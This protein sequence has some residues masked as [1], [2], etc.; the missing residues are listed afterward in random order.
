MTQLRIDDQ[1]MDHRP[2]PTERRTV[3]R[4]V[5]A[6]VLQG[7]RNGNG[8]SV[9]D[10]ASKASMAPMTWRRLEEGLDVRRRAQ[11]SVDSLLG[12]PFGTIARALNDDA[13][14][15]ELV[16]S[17]GND[18]VDARKAK[19][20]ASFLDMLAERARSGSAPVHHYRT[21]TDHAPAVDSVTASVSR[22]SAQVT[23]PISDLTRAAQLVD[24]ITRR[25]LTPAL[26]NAVAAILAAMPDLITP[27]IHDATAAVDLM[28]A[29][30]NRTLNMA[31]GEVA[32]Q[33]TEAAIAAAKERASVHERA[34]AA[35]EDGEQG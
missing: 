16:M 22:V 14:M 7:Y 28:S 20:P 21:I 13:L 15:I 26:E 5:L 18:V 27:N 17:H 10:A 29:S 19:D 8:W 6:G 9:N 4:L 33:A 1:D 32:R 31:A 2:D 24:Q 11:S 35:F 23:P 12:L 30:P 3:R 25:T 34:R